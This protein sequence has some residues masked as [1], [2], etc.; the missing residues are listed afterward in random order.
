M[1]GVELGARAPSPALSAQREL[2]GVTL[3]YPRADRVPRAGSPRGVVDATRSQTQLT[4]DRFSL[5]NHRVYDPVATAP[6]S[7]PLARGYNFF[8]ST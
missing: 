3:Q 8:T 4:F 1:I 2:S 6:G 7:V 5:T